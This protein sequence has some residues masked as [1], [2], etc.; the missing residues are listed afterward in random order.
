LRPSFDELSGELVE[1]RVGDLALWVH[2]DAVA[3]DAPDPPPLLL[4]P[5]RDAFALGNRAFLVPDRAVAK[6]VWR[7][8]GSPGTVL[9]D[10]E[11]AG[12]WRAR[13]SGRV[14]RL[15]VAM[16][17]AL[18]AKQRAGVEEQAEIV[19]AARGHDG[20]SEVELD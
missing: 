18:T 19:A 6:T 3:G 20:K 17:R 2:P 9:V 13:Q 15:T 10:G 7:P 1:A 14:L 11:I 12:T 4:L 5:P 8:R 16:H